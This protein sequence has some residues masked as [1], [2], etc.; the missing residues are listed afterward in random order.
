MSDN[1]FWSNEILHLSI[2]LRDILIVTMRFSNKVQVAENTNLSFLKKFVI[3]LYLLKMLNNQNNQ[4]FIFI[5]KW[6]G[7]QYVD[8]SI[9]DFW[10]PL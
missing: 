3:Y 5:I 2:H 10:M 6:V 4:L 1:W 7:K 8:N 9:S